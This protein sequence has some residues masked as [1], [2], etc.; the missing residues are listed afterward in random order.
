MVGTVQR[1]RVGASS[2]ASDPILKVSKIFFAS[3]RASCG[4]VMRPR[5]PGAKAASKSPPCIQCLRLASGRMEKRIKHI[6]HSD[7]LFYK[8]NV[9]PLLCSATDSQIC[10]QVLDFLRAEARLTD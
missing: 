5:S 2:V 9:I 6:S 8:K 3:E 4:G 7:Q 1:C 10:I